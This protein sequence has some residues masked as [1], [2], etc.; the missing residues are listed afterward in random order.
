LRLKLAQLFLNIG[1]SSVATV[2]EGVC[3]DLAT[4]ATTAERRLNSA[5]VEL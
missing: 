3:Y 1:V 2:M 5:A 4:T